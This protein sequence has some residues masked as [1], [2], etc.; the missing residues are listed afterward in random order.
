VRIL[1]IGGGGR[2]HALAWKL[3]RAPSVEGLVWAPGNGGA[4]GLCERA[5]LDAGDVHAVVEFA[6]GGAFD[7]VFVGPE[8]PLAA[9][10]AD[11]LQ[12]AGIPCFGPSA[13]AARLESSKAFAKGFCERHGIP[14]APCS[15]WADAGAALAH[16]RS[17]DGP[18]PLV[19]K[20]D[21]LAAGKG[22]LICRDRAEALDGAERVLLKKEFGKAGD[23]LLVET[24]LAGEE[25][26]F[27]AFCDGERAVLMP[28]A[29]DHKRVGEGDT[30]PNTGGMGAYCPAGSLAEGQAQ[31]IMDRI[32]LPT[33]AGM[34]AEGHPYRGVLYAG[35]M[36]TEGG[37]SL[38]E[39][40]CRFG[41]PE[42]QVV[43]PR[44]D[45][46][47][48]EIALA[49]AGG[50]LDPSMVAW[51]RGAAVTVVLCSAGYPGEYER[52]KAIGG[53]GEASAVRGVTVFHAGTRLEGGELLTSGGRVLNV[54]GLDETLG[55]ARQRAYEACALLRFE[56]MT[57]RR[58]IAHDL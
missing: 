30:G 18:F 47:F 45:G 21:G 1:L 43:I 36:L 20:A 31:E 10:L 55:E 6:K 34:S 38:L 11:A 13:S 4:E 3:K 8:A 9:G 25:A 16:L 32:I 7:L 54:T 14:T 5:A 51:S 56:G 29:R 12:G 58:D 41:D 57:F 24:F 39:F 35:L 46:D 17:Y 28:P 15:V 22:V 37:P 42:T 19:L 48:G 2:E 40:N 26:S 53:I 27:M 52:G 49:C 44:L 33:L 23:L 50:R